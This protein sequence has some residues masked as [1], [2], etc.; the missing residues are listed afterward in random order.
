MAASTTSTK[1]SYLTARTTSRR[2]VSAST[3][4]HLSRQQ[5]SHL[6][7]V[8]DRKN[9]VSPETFSSA[10][11]GRLLWHAMTDTSARGSFYARD[12]R[13]IWGIYRCSR[14]PLRCSR[15]LPLIFCPHEGPL[16]ANKWKKYQMADQAAS[17]Q[18]WLALI[19]SRLYC[20]ILL[21]LRRSFKVLD[22]LRPPAPA[23]GPTHTCLFSCTL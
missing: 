18:R 19:G 10:R 11:D 22:L 7:I 2:H 1:A 6:R 20:S 3:C 9:H 4:R 5:V 15:L 21:R 14:S 17:C 16:R 23:G 12:G 8:R 13:L